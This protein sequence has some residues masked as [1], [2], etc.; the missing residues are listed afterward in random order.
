MGNDNNGKAKRTLRRK[1]F[2]GIH[3]TIVV[4]KMLQRHCPEVVGDR[5]KSS[6][7]VV[8]ELNMPETYSCAKETARSAV[9]LA[10]NGYHGCWQTSRGK[11]MDSYDGL[12]LGEP[13]DEV[14]NEALSVE[15]N[16]E[17]IA[18]RKDLTIVME[19]AFRTLAYRERK[20]L[21]LRHGWG[22]CPEHSLEEIG[23]VFGIKRERVR[24]IEKKALTKMR[25]PKALRNLKGFL[26]PNPDLPRIGDNFY[27][28]SGS[29]IT[30]L[31]E[32]RAEEKTPVTI[33]LSRIGNKQFDIERL[34]FLTQRARYAMDYLHDRGES[35]PNFGG[36]MDGLLM[37]SLSRKEIYEVVELPH[38]KRLTPYD[39]EE[40]ARA[41]RKLSDR[42][43]NLLCEWGFHSISE[44]FSPSASS[45]TSP[46]TPLS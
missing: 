6:F 18:C 9:Q 27:R 19:T 2:G 1:D 12:P 8:E 44:Y 16:Q 45:S 38:I 11:F 22:G 42:H 7:K 4:G 30:L 15:G 31:K 36:L 29:L 5:R 41:S 35:F 39:H 23:K 28:I 17:D 21:Q 43:L 32:V 33:E 10:R 34:T 3:R 37:A 24:Q 25:K 40:Y 14:P 13:L 26:E 20:I 46:S